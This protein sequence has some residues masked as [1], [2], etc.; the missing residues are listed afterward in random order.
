MHSDAPASLRGY[1]RFLLRDLLGF[2][3]SLLFC[4]SFLGLGCPEAGK[5]GA[6]GRRYPPPWVERCEERD[7]G[8][9]PC[10][11]LCVRRLERVPAGRQRCLRAR[12]APSPPQLP[13]QRRGHR[14]HDALPAGEDGTTRGGGGETT[15]GSFGFQKA[16]AFPSAPRRWLSVVEKSRSVLGEQRWRDLGNKSVP[17]VSVGGINSS[18]W[19]TATV[20]HH[21]GGSGK[22]G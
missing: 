18:A 19:S 20:L 21:P 22:A 15:A 14:Q 16:G 12:R 11:L 13:A 3:S 5:H 6:R 9:D 4:G 2:K 1:Q 10:L 7:D 8:R 17:G